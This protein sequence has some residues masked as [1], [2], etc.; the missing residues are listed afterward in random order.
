MKVLDSAAVLQKYPLKTWLSSNKFRA[1]EKET[2]L[3]PLCDEETLLH[4][5]RAE[6]STHQ[7]LQDC[8]SFLF[9]SFPLQ[10]LCWLQCLGF[11]VSQAAS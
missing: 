5:S 7:S 9:I 11:A 4:Q 1:L 2:F 10:G 6:L 8:R 3:F